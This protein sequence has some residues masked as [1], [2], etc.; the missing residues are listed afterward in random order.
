M[1]LPLYFSEIIAL[2]F[3]IVALIVCIRLV[4]Y[5]LKRRWN[6]E[7]YKLVW[8]PIDFVERRSNLSYNEFV[9]EYASVGKPVIITDVLK[10]W[11]AT[12]KWTLDFFKSECG[13]IKCAVKEDKNEIE[14]LM[15]IADY[16]DYINIGNSDRRF[17]LANWFISDHPQL[18]EDYKEPIYFPN[19]LQRLPR[20]LLKKYELDNPELFIGHKDTSIGLHKD[21]NNGSAWLGMIRGRKQIVLFTPDQEELLYSGKVNVFNPNLDKFPLYAKTNSV[22]VILEAGEILYIPPNWWHHVRNLENTIAVGSLLLNEWNSELFFQSITE[23]N[24]IKGHLLPLVLEFPWLGK[25]LFA[26]GVI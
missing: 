17:Y 18:L 22:E 25:T 2:S 26:I 12:T 7:K 21:P 13:T 19:W 11:K 10:D 16:I 15:T 3:L 5:L 1:Q 24:P 20:K 23:K 6:K 8:T 9:K 14:G 4:I